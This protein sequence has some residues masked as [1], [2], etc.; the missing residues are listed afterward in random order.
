MVF[1]FDVGFGNHRYYIFFLLFLSIVCDWIIYESFI[2]KYKFFLKQA[3]ELLP[4]AL[5]LVNSCISHS[6]W[7]TINHTPN[8]N[9]TAAS[10]T[11]HWEA[12]RNAQSD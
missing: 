11:Q 8:K 2:C 6:D 10:E 3:H 9:E 7:V 12:S 4:H 5:F 1:L